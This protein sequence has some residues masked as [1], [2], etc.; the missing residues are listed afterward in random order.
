MKRFIKDLII[1]EFKIWFESVGE[2]FFRVIQVFE[3]FYKKNVIDV[4]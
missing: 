1:D 4:M 3:W 2:K